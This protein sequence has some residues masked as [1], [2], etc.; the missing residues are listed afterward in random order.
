MIDQNLPVD[1]TPPAPAPVFVDG[2]GRRQRRVRRGGLILLIPAALYLALLASNILGGPRVDAPF[3]PGGAARVHPTPTSPPASPD[4]PAATTV[5]HTGAATRGTTASTARPG[6]PQAA[7]GTATT[8][9]PRPT[10]PT[11]TTTPAPAPTH[12]KST[13][14]PS[15]RPTKTP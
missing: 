10:T 9:Q 14:Q 5:P 7:P 2:S 8:A 1:R 15:R 11:A 6:A 13:T 12:G 4:A 3:L